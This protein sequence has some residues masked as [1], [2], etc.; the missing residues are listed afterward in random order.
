MRWQKYRA[1][2]EGEFRQGGKN[3]ITL[4]F[5]W[6]ALAFLGVASVVVLMA[7]RHI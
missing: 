4:A 7:K 5:V 1:S 2:A 3:V 6:M